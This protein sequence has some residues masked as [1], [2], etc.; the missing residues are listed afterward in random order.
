VLLGEREQFKQN[1]KLQVSGGST[2][3]VSIPRSWVER[4]NLKAGDSVSM[5]KNENNSLTVFPAASWAGE[6]QA[7][8]VVIGPNDSDESIRRK[9][10]AMYLAGYKAITITAKGIRLGPGQINAVRSFARSSMIGTEIIESSPECVTI[11]TLTRLPEM[12]FDVALLRMATMTMD[13]HQEALEALETADPEYAEEVVM[14]DD[15]I[16]RFT[17]YMLRNLT[18][19]V[20]DANLLRAMSLEGPA[21]CLYYRTVISRIERIADHATL[22]AKRVKYLTE[23][24]DSDI[25]EKTKQ[26]SRSVMEMFSRAINAMIRSDYGAAEEVTEATA[27]VQAAQEELMMSVKDSAPNATVIKFVLDSIRRSAE[28]TMDIAEVVMDRNIR[29]V[30]A[31][32]GPSRATV[33]SKTILAKTPPAA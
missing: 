10:V 15:E 14:L 1:R 22:I 4:M 21:D 31:D 18:M 25:L 19:A 24:I 8:S 6:E 11:K 17:F 5:V 7:A 16:D 30:I 28:Y 32:I 29:S 26:L 13:T 9:I 2:Y 12:T 23:H 20:G 33:N 27:K 3:I